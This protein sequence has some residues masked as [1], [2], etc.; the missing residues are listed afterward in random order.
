MRAITPAIDSRGFL[1]R[2]EVIA[3]V[4]KIERRLELRDDVEEI[5]F[6]R[7]IAVVSVPSS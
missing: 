2:H 5:L 7:A 4:G 1:R 6:D 3:L